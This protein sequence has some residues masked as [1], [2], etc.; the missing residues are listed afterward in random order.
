MSF[1][2]IN[3]IICKLDLG[4]WAGSIQRQ[5]KETNQVNHPL[6][7]SVFSDCAECL[8]KLFQRSGFLTWI[9]PAVTTCEKAW[10]NSLKLNHW[11]LSRQREFSMAL[12]AVLDVGLSFFC[13]F[14]TSTF[15]D[16]TSISSNLL[17]Y[18][19]VI[20]LWKPGYFLHGSSWGWGGIVCHKVNQI[21]HKVYP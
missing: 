1:T 3:S 11:E 19:T 18:T 4:V 6:Q 15:S 20:P 12:H 10:L 21:Y 16:G 5:W 2:C 13:F 14:I 7:V 17:N 8:G 9:P